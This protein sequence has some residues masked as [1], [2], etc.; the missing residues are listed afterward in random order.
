MF[1][2]TILENFSDAD[3]RYRGRGNRM[4]QYRDKVQS[5][6]GRI[7]VGQ[8]V[9]GNGIVGETLLTRSGGDVVSNRIGIGGK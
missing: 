9:A 3:S 2:P 1:K 4:M 7:G 8:L 6:V 5:Y